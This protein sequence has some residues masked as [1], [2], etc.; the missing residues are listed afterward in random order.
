[1]YVCAWEVQ[2]GDPF[3]FLIYVMIL[4]LFPPLRS[5]HIVAR[6]RTGEN[7]R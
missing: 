6:K 5:T 2:V 3:T 4:E 7:T 1:M